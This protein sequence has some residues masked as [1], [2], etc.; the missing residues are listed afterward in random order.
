MPIPPISCQI[1]NKSKKNNIA[2]LR[3][4]KSMRSLSQYS[5]RFG[6]AVSYRHSNRHGWLCDS[7]HGGGDER[8]LQCDLPGQR[9]G[10][11]LREKKKKKK[12]REFC[13]WTTR[14]QI[15]PGTCNPLHMLHWHKRLQANGA[16]FSRLPKR[17]YKC[18][19]VIWEVCKQNKMYGYQK[20]SASSQGQ[21][22]NMVWKWAP[23]LYI[24]IIHWL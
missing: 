20:H 2:Y 8:G 15:K 12:R 22:S 14:G 18:P 6:K 24:Y 17:L 10:Q 7:V 21:K 5:S 1:K 3:I 4:K 13:T 11:V 16:N 19:S 9:W 23:L